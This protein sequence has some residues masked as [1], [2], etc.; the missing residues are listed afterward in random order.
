M[1][2]YRCLSP[3]YERVSDWVHSSVG[4]TSEDDVHTGTWRSL[5]DGSLRPTRLTTSQKG[6]FRLDISTLLHEWRS[7]HVRG[8]FPVFLVLT[9]PFILWWFPCFIWWSLD[10]IS[11]PM[12]TWRTFSK[13]LSVEFLRVT[14]FSLMSIYWLVLVLLLCNWFT[15]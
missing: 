10:G 3:K 8:W 2:P 6:R 7:V 14:L 12:D 4:C 5:P 11:F 9:N 15:L 13:V 1:S